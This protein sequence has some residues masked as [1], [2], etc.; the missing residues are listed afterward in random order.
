MSCSFCDQC[1]FCQQ[2]L[3]SVEAL[4]EAKIKERVE[5]KVRIILAALKEEGRAQV[6][7]SDG[8]TISCGD[9][10]ERVRMAVVL[11]H[12]HKVHYTETCDEYVNPVE[13]RCNRRIAYFWI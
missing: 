3:L 9:I 7:V 2:Q 1:S 5:K 6:I 11:V 4:K 8:D 13:G 10:I 12:D